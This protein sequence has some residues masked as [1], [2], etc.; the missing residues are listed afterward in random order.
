MSRGPKVVDMECRGMDRL[1]MSTYT[2]EDPLHHHTSLIHRDDIH[3]INLFH[4]DSGSSSM[5]YKSGIVVSV[6]LI[7]EK[8]GYVALKLLL[9]IEHLLENYALCLVSPWWL[10]L[11]SSKWSPLGKC[12]SLGGLLDEPS[13]HSRSYLLFPTLHPFRLL[14]FWDFQV[15]WPK[16]GLY[17][18]SWEEGVEGPEAC[19]WQEIKIQS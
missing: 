3:H 14:I 12:L 6:T 5:R 19:S 9:I 15:N 17:L 16:K 10:T 11:C 7:L 4:E 18:I 8:F 13:Y 2:D 1:L